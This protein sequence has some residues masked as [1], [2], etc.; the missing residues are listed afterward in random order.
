VKKLKNISRSGYLAVSIMIISMV[1]FSL[2]FNLHSDA[3]AATF[4]NTT[5]GSQSAGAANSLIATRFTMPNEN[6][7]LTALSTY[8][9]SAAAAPNNQFQMA[10]YADNGGVPGTLISSSSTQT[11]APASWNTVNISVSLS[12]N[13][14][15][16][17][18][19]NTNGS[20][21]VNFNNAGANTTYSRS[22]TF[23]TMPSSFGSAST[24]AISASLY[25]TYTPQ[26]GT[27]DTTAPTVS[28]SSPSA[29]STVSGTVSFNANAS[30]NVGIAGVTFRIDGS[31]LGAEDTSS[32]YS[33][34][35]DTT[36]ASNGSHSLTA[37]ARDTSNNTTTSS[38]IS[39]TVSNAVAPPPPPPPAG[40][41]VPPVGI[42][43][44][45]NW[46]LSTTGTIQNVSSGGTSTTF[47][48]SG[49]ASNPLIFHGVNNPV[50]T[51]TVTISGS[52]VIVENIKWW[53]S[54]V[55]R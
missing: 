21:A 44:P 16:W 52:Y 2:L 55:Y 10:I 15:Y 34:S 3:L 39:V 51:G 13:T 53:S 30:D 25:G 5:P 23:G 17:L 20:S 33:F 29:G 50:F 26:G 38:I 7:T 37:V 18:A 35:W 48:G 8:F 4:G 12:A 36:T 40:S 49:T 41:W 45:G 54:K 14:V 24:N 9:G 19:V 32:P 46:F 22:Q 27:A 11:V 1:I 28:I 43:H 47:T 31:A 42:P 6:G